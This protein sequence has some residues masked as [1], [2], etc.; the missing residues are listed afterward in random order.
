MFTVDACFFVEWVSQSAF[1]F[2]LSGL[3]LQR[4]FLYKYKHQEKGS[5]TNTTARYVEEKRI[6]TRLPEQR[7]PK[8]GNQA[9]RMKR[10]ARFRTC[11]NIH[12]II[13]PL[14]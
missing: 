14:S 10:P 6:A 11:Q 12:K 4:E 8:N 3:L 2:S 7:G 1:F 9:D 5:L 13:F